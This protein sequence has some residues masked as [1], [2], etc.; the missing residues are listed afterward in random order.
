MRDSK[1]VNE[2]TE[3]SSD[4]LNAQ[5]TPRANYHGDIN[6]NYIVGSTGA[7]TIYGAGGKLFRR[8]W[9]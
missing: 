2:L 1:S 8:T 4:V 6:D 9:W 7:D 3:T 5:I